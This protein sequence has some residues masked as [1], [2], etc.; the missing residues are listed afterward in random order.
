M[1]RHAFHNSV[2][3]VAMT[4]TLG[5]AMLALRDACLDHHSGNDLPDTNPRQ[6][7]DRRMSL[8]VGFLGLSN[9]VRRV[10]RIQIIGRDG[11]GSEYLLLP[12]LIILALLEGAERYRSCA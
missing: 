10:E 3:P 8:L 5:A 2:D 7:P 9:A 6:V 12:P 4:Q 1:D 11:N